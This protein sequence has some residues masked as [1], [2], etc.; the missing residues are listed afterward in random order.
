[1]YLNFAGV[2]TVSLYIGQITCEIASESKN[3]NLSLNEVTNTTCRHYFCR[4]PVYW[5]W[6]FLRWVCYVARHWKCLGK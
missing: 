2:K 5:K 4:L 1:M 6:H 3:M